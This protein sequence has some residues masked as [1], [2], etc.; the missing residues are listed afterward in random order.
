MAYAG[1]FYELMLAVLAHVM[2]ADGSFAGAAVALTL[3]L[4]SYVSGHKLAQE[5]RTSNP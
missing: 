4:A 1:F 5:S 3:L 2:V